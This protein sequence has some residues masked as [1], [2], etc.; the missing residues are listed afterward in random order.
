MIPDQFDSIFSKCK[1]NV[2]EE[3]CSPCTSG[4][5]NCLKT[6][7]IYPNDV[8]ASWYKSFLGSA[9]CVLPLGS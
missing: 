6:E 9:L 4:E 2:F 5:K 7:H 8:V 1:L 3:N